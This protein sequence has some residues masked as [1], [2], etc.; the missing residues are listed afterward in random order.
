MDSIIVPKLFRKY[1]AWLSDLWKLK[2]WKLR[3]KDILN[4]YI[5]IYGN[6]VYRKNVEKHCFVCEA[7]RQYLL[8]SWIFL[9][10]KLCSAFDG[11]AL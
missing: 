5:Y 9:H 11:I 10:V 4:F 8:A 2:V 6:V 7:D 1:C 3:E